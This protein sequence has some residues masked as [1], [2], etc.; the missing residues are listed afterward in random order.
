[1]LNLRLGVSVREKKK[2][3]ESDDSEDYWTASHKGGLLVLLF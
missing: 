3:G 2:G 1:M